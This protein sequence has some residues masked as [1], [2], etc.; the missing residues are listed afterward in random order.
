MFQSIDGKEPSSNKLVPLAQMNSLI[1][2]QAPG[3]LVMGGNK[4]RKMTNEGN[5]LLGEG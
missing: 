5:S 2:G 4:I 3:G 1:S